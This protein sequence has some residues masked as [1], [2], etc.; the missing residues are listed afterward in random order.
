MTAALEADVIFINFLLSKMFLSIKSIFNLFVRLNYDHGKTTNIQI[1][2]YIGKIKTPS[3]HFLHRDF[4][5]KISLHHFFLVE[6]FHRTITLKL[7]N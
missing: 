1:K 7:N 5:L 6:H 3:K 4:P 2:K